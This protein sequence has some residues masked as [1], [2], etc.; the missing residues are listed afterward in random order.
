MPAPASRARNLKGRRIL[1]VEDNVLIAEHIRG[2]LSDTGCRV[3]GPAPRLS[4]GLALVRDSDALDGA[5]LDIN[6]G[7]ETCFEIAAELRG[8]SVPFLFLTGYDNKSAIPAE[9]QAA[10]FLSKPVDESRL[11]SVATR[12]FA[13]AGQKASG[14]ET[15]CA[16]SLSGKHDS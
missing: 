10:P 14:D 1:V 11:L 2:L 9:F 3:V 6:L 5:V 7:S 13:D 8:R 16:A 15:A 12:L 4:D